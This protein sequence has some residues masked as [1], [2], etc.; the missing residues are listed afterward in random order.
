MVS[1]I[2]RAVSSSVSPALPF[3]PAR[4]PWTMQSTPWLPRMRLSRAT[5]AR[6]GTF[7]RVSVS[8]VSRLAIISGRAAF[9]A[10]EIGNGAVQPRA[11]DDT[12]PVHEIA[13]RRDA[14]AKRYGEPAGWADLAR[15]CG[16]LKARRACRAARPTGRSSSPTPSSVS[17]FREGAAAALR[18]RR[19]ARR[20]SARR[21]SR[22]AR[23]ASLSGESG[24]RVIRA[25]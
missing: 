2:W 19:L 10:P 7:S 9:L 25:L 21:F 12:N 20:A 11:A 18:R 1:T 14:P 23:A 22:A 16:Q 17:P 15:F 4:L 24:E 6:R 8:S 5:S 3:W 13:L